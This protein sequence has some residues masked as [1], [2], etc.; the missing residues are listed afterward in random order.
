MAPKTKQSSKKATAATPSK[1]IAKGT[2]EPKT[3]KTDVPKKDTEL[4]GKAVVV[5]GTLLWAEDD[6]N[7]WWLTEKG[8]QGADRTAGAPPLLAPLSSCA[9][10]LL[11]CAAR[12]SMASRS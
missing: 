4:S 10:S 6:E 11:G 12:H 1:T 8:L 9:K 3:P 2:K 5:C 7:S